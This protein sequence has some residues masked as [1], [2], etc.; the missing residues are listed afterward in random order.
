LGQLWRLPHALCDNATVV[1][2]P[3]SFFMGTTMSTI[4]ETKVFIQ[5]AHAGQV[6]KSGKDYYLHPIAVME[7]LPEHTALDVK[8][9]A[10]LHDV[11]EDTT[12]T[13]Q[14]LLA[15][16][17]SER[18]IAAVEAVTQKPGDQRSYGE[19]IDDLIAQGNPDAIMVKFADMSENTDPVR[20]AA[21]EPDVRERLERKYAEPKTALA[22]AVQTILVNDLLHACGAEPDVEILRGKFLDCHNGLE[23]T[24]TPLV[25]TVEAA[26]EGLDGHSRLVTLFRQAAVAIAQHVDNGEDNTGNHAYH[27]ALHFAKVVVNFRALATLHN[28]LHP[29]EALSNEDI[30][31][32]ILAATAHDI[33]HNGQGNTV[34]KQ[35]VQF[36]LE[37]LAID[38]ALEWADPKNAEDR[39]LLLDA[40][41]PVYATDVSSD[42]ANMS[43]AHYVRGMHDAKGAADNLPSTPYSGTIRQALPTRKHIVI[44]SLLHDAD[45]LSS[46]LDEKSH[47]RESCR[48][49]AEFGAQPSAKSSLFFMETLLQGR[50]TTD[51]A[52]RLTDSFVKSQIAKLNPA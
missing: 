8:L 15:M 16:G 7:R 13:R 14:D 6:D 50:N 44:A 46:L 38:T 26:F 23:A 22:K 34:D 45:V 3:I 11:L 9:A 52:R 4:D 43:P 36:R 12:Y 20:L 35:H 30:A 31:G 2:L 24:G 41:A 27:N 1:E 32:G 28:K 17:Y 42:G 40:L 21:L 33:R 48:V 25:Q 49:M 39:G 18:T 29:D 47:Q 10:L 19:K 51:A 37:Q 5:K